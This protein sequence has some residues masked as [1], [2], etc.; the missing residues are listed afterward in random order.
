MLKG[1]V[2]EIYVRP[3]MPYGSEGWCLDESEMGI[4]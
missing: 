1:A 2:Y 4:L 3:A